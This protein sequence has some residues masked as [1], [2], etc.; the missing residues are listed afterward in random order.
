MFLRATSTDA[1]INQCLLDLA[2]LKQPDVV[3]YSKKVALRPFEDDSSLQFYSRK[4]DC[5]LFAFGSSSKKRPANLV[6]GRMYN[7]QVLDMIEFGV[8]QFQSL[9]EFAGKYKP[10]LGSKPCFVLDGALWRTDERIAV[11]GN[12]IVDF[13]RG[14][15]LQKVN[16][17]GLDH[18]IVLTAVS[19]DMIYFRHYAVTLKKSGTKVPRVELVDVGPSMQLIVRRAHIGAETVRREAIKVPLEVTGKKRKNVSTNLFG[20]TLGRI[21]MPRQDLKSLGVNIHKRIKR[22]VPRESEHADD[23]V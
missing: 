16:L 10:A 20:E 5:S 6:L 18:V 15:V 4:S 1:V 11:V 9:Q 12:L 21:H 23:A 2:A 19:S 8:G 14:Q 13:F 22:S 3:K 17:A 7:Y